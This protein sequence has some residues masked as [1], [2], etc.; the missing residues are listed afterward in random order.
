[1][2]ANREGNL[3]SGDPPTSGGALG[4]CRPSEPKHGPEVSIQ[5]I[6]QLYWA[7]HSPWAE[8][9]LSYARRAAAAA[10]AV[11]RGG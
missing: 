5:P 2:I 6:V 3:P 9:R 4:L 1:V 8:R 11:R 7:R 10:A